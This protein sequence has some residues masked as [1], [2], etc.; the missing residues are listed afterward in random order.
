M[1]ILSKVH[2][3]GNFKSQNSLKFSFIN[4]WGSHSNCV[5][6]KFF[7][8]SNA[9]D[10]L[11]LR[12][13][14]L[15]DSIDFSNFSV[16]SYLPLIRKDSLTNGLA[17]YVKDRLP[18]CMGLICRK[19]C[20]FLFKFLT[21]FTSFRVLPLFL[22]QSS[23][24]SLCKVLYAISSSTDKTLSINPSADVFVFGDSS[25]HHMGWLTYSGG[26]VRPA[27]LCYNFI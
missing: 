2:K 10:I 7:L 16:R 14:N 18:V 23:F 1:T 20:G 15:R 25:I 11:A 24:S 19:F 4:V 17:V 6:C 9:P 13:T 26:T 27:E 8:K 3:Q 22:Y 21:A 5:G 12:E